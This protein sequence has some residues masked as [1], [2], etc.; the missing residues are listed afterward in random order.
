MSYIQLDFHSHSL[1]RNV[2]LNIF[3]PD[4][5]LLPAAEQ[6]YPT[7]Y[8]L[9][10]FSASGKELSTFLHF[11]TQCLLNGIAVVIP[12]GDN[13]FYLDKP[14]RLALYSQYVSQE[15]V[16][17]TRSILPLSHKREETYIGGISMGGYGALVH[18]FRYPEKFGKIAALS[19]AIDVAAVLNGNQG[20]FGDMFADFFETEEAYYN[21]TNHPINGLKEL[22]AKG[23]DLPS[24]FIACGFQ[25]ELVYVSN[26]EF[27]EQLGKLNVPLTYI[28]DDGGHDVFF[29]DKYLPATFAFLKQ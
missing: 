12:D 19:P 4:G 9:P 21:S 3:L 11:R 15:L 10:G 20:L 7:I 5:E 28:E 6:P 26:K 17:Y 18:G 29:W 2:N 22:L 14:E 25:D 23:Q 13:S 16:N 8:F 27:A 24:V 1:N